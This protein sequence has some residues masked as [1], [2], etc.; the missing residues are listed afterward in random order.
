MLDRVC[1]IRCVILVTKTNSV[2][3]LIKLED[4]KAHGC[5]LQ[6]FGEIASRRNDLSNLVARITI[7]KFD[8]DTQQT[9][10]DSW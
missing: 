2:S 10:C 3:L 6:R 4:D 1:Y 8:I 7:G 9:I 5:S